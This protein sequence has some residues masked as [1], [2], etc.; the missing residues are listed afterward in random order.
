[1]NS[2]VKHL[3]ALKVIGHKLDANIKDKEYQYKLDSS[4][5]RRRRELSGHRWTPVKYVK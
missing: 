5:L 2:T 4:L 3:K 1:M